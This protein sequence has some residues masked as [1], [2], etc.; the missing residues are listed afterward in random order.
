MAPIAKK[1]P[2][3]CF[4]QGVIKL[5]FFL[6]GKFLNLLFLSFVFLKKVLRFCVL[7]A[8]SL[9]LL[10]CFVFVKLTCYELVLPSGRWSLHFLHYTESGKTWYLLIIDGKENLMGGKIIIRNLL[11]VYFLKNYSIET[12]I[13]PKLFFLN[14][15][16]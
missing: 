9:A 3:G 5:Q 14:F 8:L 7:N 1:G 13:S 2:E 11:Y 12:L 16:I 6:M 15:L 4:F 10:F